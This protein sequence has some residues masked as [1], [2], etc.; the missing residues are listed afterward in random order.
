VHADGDDSN[1]ARGLDGGSVPPSNFR[2]A[3]YLDAGSLDQGSKDQLSPLDDL[4]GGVR[5][6]RLIRTTW[7]LQ[8]V[9]FPNALLVA[10]VFWFV[11]YP[12]VTFNGEAGSTDDLSSGAAQESRNY[13]DRS[14]GSSSVGDGDASG[15]GIIVYGADVTGAG[16][17]NP[18][19]GIA[20]TASADHY[21]PWR[22]FMCTQEHGANFLL[23]A[24]DV[25]L[26]RAPY[27]IA[28]VH[29]VRLN[30]SVPP[31]IFLRLSRCQI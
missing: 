9:I 26:S 30:S 17:A 21:T 5:P 23:M 19:L 10:L 20:A 8:N 18:A 24:A 4:D 31:F 16:A 28:H 7:L 22:Y 14:V 29:H 13:I 27:R 3:L 25:F 11:V 6:D 15:D 12:G 2:L 1:N